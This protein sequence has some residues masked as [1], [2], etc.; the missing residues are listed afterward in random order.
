MSPNDEYVI[1]FNS[2]RHV[3]LFRTGHICLFSK[4]L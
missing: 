2:N 1:N 4:E 3:V